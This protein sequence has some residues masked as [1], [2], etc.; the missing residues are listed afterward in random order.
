MTVV[1]N[2]K[3]TKTICEQLAEHG[4]TSATVDHRKGSNGQKIIVRTGEMEALL[5][6]IAQLAPGPV[7]EVKIP[8]TIFR[9]VR[10]GSTDVSHA[11]WVD[12]NTEAVGDLFGSWCYGDNSF[13]S[14][15]DGTEIEDYSVYEDYE[16][17]AIDDE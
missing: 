5:M 9:C 6:L 12:L 7:T 10:C 11:S 13:C 17:K 2:R 14:A 8:K 16:H 3:Y 4:I 1:R 15:C